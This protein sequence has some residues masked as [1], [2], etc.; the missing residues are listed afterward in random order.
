MWGSAALLSTLR[1]AV[2]AYDLDSSSLVSDD[3]CLSG[4]AEECSLG[5]RQLRGELSGRSAEEQ[6]VPDKHPTW[7][8][9]VLNKA[10]R[11]KGAVCLD[12]TPPAYYI[13]KGYGS[14]ARKWMFHL[15]GGGWCVDLAD[16]AKRAAS[17]LGSSKD[18]HTISAKNKMLD[19]YD[20]GAQGLLSRSCAVNPDFCTWNKVYIRYC[21]GASFSGEVDHPV[22][23]QGGRKLY[24]RGRRILDAVLDDLLYVQGMVHGTDLIAKGC[25]AG[26]LGV[27]VNLDH[28]AGRMPAT[29]TVKGIPECGFFMEVPTYK[30]QHT[31]PDNFQKIV[32]MQN[33]T[34]FLNKE[35]V[36]A[37]AGDS[38]RCFLPQNFVS[39]V[40]TPHFAINSVYD[41][42]QMQY[43][44]DLPKSCVKN[45]ICSPRQRSAADKLRQ[46]MISNVKKQTASGS[47]FFLYN[48]VTHC[49]QTNKNA[50]FGT[51]EDRM[52]SVTHHRPTRLRNAIEEW[53]KEGVTIRSLGAAGP[54]PN[55]E[56]T[57]HIR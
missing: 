20:G 6:L 29:L 34:G 40:K 10:A 47:G 12:G 14:G 3:S 17:N 43:F 4:N 50:R 28:I 46:G 33:I 38:W 19:Y 35:C 7:K 54:G 18:Y 32:A 22:A 56:I 25:S 27:W 5:L 8:T 31:W 48:C 30:G 55:S 42:F 57:C 49:G 36:R 16:C 2:F 21:D 9:V 39:H 37:H 15:Q 41:A 11:E 45:N 53:Y 52:M 13:E 23:V 24:F 1:A 44:L 51:L 26:G